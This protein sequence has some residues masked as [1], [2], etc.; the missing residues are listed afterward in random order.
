MRLYDFRFT[1]TNLRYEWWHHENPKCRLFN[2]RFEMRERA[3]CE[4]CG[5]TPAESKRTDTEVL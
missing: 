1:G 4:Y 2:Q 5:F 3:G